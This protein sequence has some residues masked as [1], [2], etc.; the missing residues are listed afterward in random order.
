MNNLQYILAL[1]C[2]GLTMTSCGDIIK[3]HTSKDNVTKEIE[4]TEGFSAIEAYNT[5][6]IEYTDGPAK[7]TL[8]A[9]DNLISRIQVYVKDGVLYITEQEE[10]Q[11]ILKGMMRSK[12]TVSYPGVN[13]L[14]TYGTGDINIDTAK[15]DS[16]FLN[17]YGTGDIKADHL[18]CTV[19]KA[20]T[21]GTGD[22]EV[23]RLNCREAL[24]TTEGTGDIEVYNISANALTANTNGTGDITLSGECHT[25]EY[26]KN[27][28][29]EIDAKRLKVAQK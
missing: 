27:G 26:G 15:A 10:N 24:L 8:S 28:T 3:V 17:T 12:L 14:G 18:S 9:P 20:S 6:D 23:K 1:C 16:L 2:L 13:N 7:I 19:L 22:I 21:G 11:T 25:F 29:G 4:I 5:T